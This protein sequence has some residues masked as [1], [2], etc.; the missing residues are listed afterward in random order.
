MKSLFNTFAVLFLIV[1]S[2]FTALTSAKSNGALHYGDCKVK[3]G[4]ICCYDENGQEHC[5][6]K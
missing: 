6:P 2:N 1:I 4:K 3:N 5:R